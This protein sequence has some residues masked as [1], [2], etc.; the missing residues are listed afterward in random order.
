MHFT[1]VLVFASSAALVAAAPA[2]APGP[3]MVGVDDVILFGKGGRFTIM[4]R[5]QV[6]DLEKLRSSRIP[7][8]MPSHLDDTL[9]AL[10]IHQSFKSDESEESN[11]TLR[12]RAT[13][14]IIPGP[15]SRFLG[16]D[17][18]TSQIVKGT[19]NTC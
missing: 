11:A 14:I 5:S 1:Q 18:Q 9:V 19:S 6:D 4:K 10:P 12:K 13:S 3:I 17:V 7:P 2:S 16:W 15:E 8:P